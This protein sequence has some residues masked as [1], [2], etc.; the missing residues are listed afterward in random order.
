MKLFLS[1]FNEHEKIEPPN[2]PNKEYKIN[3]WI[4]LENTSIYLVSAYV[5]D[6]Y[7]VLLFCKEMDLIHELFPD[8][9]YSNH[10]KE[11][12][13]ERLILQKNIK[14]S[15]LNDLCVEINASQ[16][17]E[18]FFRLFTY[19]GN[20][21]MIE[22]SKDSYEEQYK[23]LSTYINE[24]KEIP[25]NLR[26]KK[27]LFYKALYDFEQP[28]TEINKLK[29]FIRKNKTVTS[30]VDKTFKV[31]FGKSNIKIHYNSP[32]TQEE[33]FIIIE[34]LY[35]HNFLK[36]MEEKIESDNLDI[37]ID[38]EMKKSLDKDVLFLVFKTPEEKLNYS[39]Y[40]N[41]YLHSIMDKPKNIK[42]MSYYVYG[43]DIKPE[44]GLFIQKI[45][46]CELDKNEKIKDT[47][48]L[49]LMT[50]VNHNEPTLKTIFERCFL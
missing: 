14:T 49:T 15:N 21:V 43:N 45:C 4:A 10:D 1:D 13:Y 20:K 29:L 5:Y 38:D 9:C 37:E 33:S 11:T 26:D 17:Y 42:T 22:E 6:K 31:P 28:V 12:Y 47:Y 46:L 35:K 48:D 36:D 19:K 27:L 32:D 23:Y 16:I 18:A 24:K 3:E 41:S 2:V 34:E 39:F 30:W 44:D 50:V 8:N 40:R 25:K 7:V